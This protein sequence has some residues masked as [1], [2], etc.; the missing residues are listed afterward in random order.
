MTGPETPRQV[1]P[2]GTFPLGGLT[3]I[4]L[5]QIYNGPYAPYLLALSVKIAPRSGVVHAPIRGRRRGPP[6]RY[7]ER[8]QTLGRRQPQG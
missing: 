2:A 6:L 8:L 4:D 1:S 7:A 3:V 5:S